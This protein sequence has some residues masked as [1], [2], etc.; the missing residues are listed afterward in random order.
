MST[1]I[2]F[3]VYTGRERRE[4]VAYSGLKIYL[5]ITVTSLIISTGPIN[6]KLRK[7]FCKMEVDFGVTKKPGEEIAKLPESSLA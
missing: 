1:I 2:T 7:F 4:T 5:E 6:G 3:C